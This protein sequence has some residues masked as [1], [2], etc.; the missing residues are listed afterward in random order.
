[1]ELVLVLKSHNDRDGYLNQIV[2]ADDSIL[3]ADE[4]CKL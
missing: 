1:M 2:Y 3:A 4:E